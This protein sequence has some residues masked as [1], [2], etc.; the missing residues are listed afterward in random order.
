MGNITIS[1]GKDVK[2][3]CMDFEEDEE[4]LMYISVKVVM[5]VA[6]LML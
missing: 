6:V 4:S 2:M 3:V 5:A 1:W